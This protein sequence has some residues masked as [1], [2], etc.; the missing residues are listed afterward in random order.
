MKIGVVIVVVV[1]AGVPVFA[2]LADD[3]SATETR[4]AIQ[5]FDSGTTALAGSN[6]TGVSVEQSLGDAVRLDGTQSSYVSGESAPP[7]DG[8]WSVA[9]WVRV[10][11]TTSTQLVYSD[12]ARTVVYNGSSGEW[13]AGYYDSS[14]GET[15]RVRTPATNETS[16]THL[17]A[18][19]D[20]SVLELAVNNSVAASTVTDGANATTVP[21]AAG[22]LD[23]S[24]D[25]TRVFDAALASGER[26]QLIDRP[27]A[28]LTSTPR[29][30]RVMFDSFSTSPSSFPAFFIGG[31]VTA[32]SV[33]L[34]DGFAGETTAAGTDYSL[35]GDT[36]STLGGGS[37]DGAP[38]AYVTW[39]AEFSSGFGLLTDLLL[40]FF[41]LFAV[42]YLSKEVTD[43]L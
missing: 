6:I 12:P 42:G 31:D 24:L 32:G 11:D 35:S 9:T 7:D 15:W 19:H 29:Q 4:E 17:T 38:A 41:G 26:Q 8:T 21:L 30:S 43:R 10:N 40:V 33:S 36:I 25:E 28:P 23:G 20:G 5:S 34:V 2:S 27:T 39:T 1:A 13:V 37:L 16:W 3:S 22:N 14:S 18:S